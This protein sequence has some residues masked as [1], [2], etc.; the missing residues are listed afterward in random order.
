MDII[1]AAVI[2]ALKSFYILS[3]IGQ[4]VGLTQYSIIK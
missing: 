2:R 3:K 1:S 4:T